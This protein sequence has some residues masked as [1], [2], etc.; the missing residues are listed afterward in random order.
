MSQKIEAPFCTVPCLLSPSGSRPGRSLGSSVRY[1]G[2]DSQR[3]LKVN[4]PRFGNAPIS[5]ALI[6]RSLTKRDLGGD[7]AHPVDCLPIRLTTLTRDKS[8]AT[9][10]NGKVRLFP[11]SFL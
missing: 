6:C 8:V 5:A 4:S 7:P 3:L 11:G 1:L 2:N 10:S 9:I